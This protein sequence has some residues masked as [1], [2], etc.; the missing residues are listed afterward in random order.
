MLSRGGHPGSGGTPLVGR[1]L[2][3]DCGAPGVHGIPLVPTFQTKVIR[4]FRHLDKRLPPVAL[5]KRK[6][7]VQQPGPNTPS[8]PSHGS[9]SPWP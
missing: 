6:E 7:N 2:Q 3:P 5:G 4:H 8:H 1:G 9:G